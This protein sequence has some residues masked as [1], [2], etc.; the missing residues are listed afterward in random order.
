MMSLWYCT[1]TA[2]VWYAVPAS[3]AYSLSV[4]WSRY[5]L[6]NGHVPG[7][8]RKGST[9]AWADATFFWNTGE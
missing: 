5:R 9:E 3:H 6:G 4:C 1:C 7:R 2:M 8:D